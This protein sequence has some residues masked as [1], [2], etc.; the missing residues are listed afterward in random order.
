MLDFNRLHQLLS[1][2]PLT[3]QWRWRKDGRLAGAI[4]KGYRLIKIDKRTYRSSRLVWLY[5]TGQWPSGKVDHK[6]RVRS[7]D[8]WA[9]LR[10]AT[11]SQNKANSL[12]SGSPNKTGYQGVWVA[13]RRRLKPYEAVVRKDGKRVYRKCFASPEEAHAA[14]VAAKQRIYG[15]FAP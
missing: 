6:D 1:Y 3:G 8:T 11:S 2:N 5:M 4:S 10:S 14:Y 7:N 13:K 12:R 9:N 15:E